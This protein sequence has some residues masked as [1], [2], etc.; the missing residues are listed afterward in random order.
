M[1]YLMLSILWLISGSLAAQENQVSVF[2]HLVD[3]TPADWQAVENP[4]RIL[5]LQV[6]SVNNP[7][8]LNDEALKNLSRFP[9]LR[10]LQL[11]GPAVEGQ[12]FTDKGLVHVLK[13]KHLEALIIY[14][15]QVTDEGIQQLKTLPSI[16]TIGFCFNA[17]TQAGVEKLQS[18]LP[19]AHIER[20]TNKP[21]KII[22]P[23]GCTTTEYL[24]KHLHLRAKK[25]DQ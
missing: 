1:R 24:D 16:Q 2:V 14:N 22:L 20:R 19:N 11:G 7:L 13:L 23:T 4:E 25:A 17:I 10:T 9:N 18:Q 15:S 21:G 8:C 12:G 5:T 6:L 3:P